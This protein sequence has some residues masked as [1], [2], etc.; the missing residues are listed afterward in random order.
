MDRRE[1]LAKLGRFGRDVSQEAQRIRSLGDSARFVRWFVSRAKRAAGWRIAKAARPLRRTARRLRQP[2]R[3][4]YRAT[5][6]RLNKTLGR[7]LPSRVLAPLRPQKHRRDDVRP[8][9]Y[10]LGPAIAASGPRAEA[11]LAASSRVERAVR[12]HTEAL[13]VDTPDRAHEAGFA[14]PATVVAL[15]E[16]DPRASVPAFDA[17]SF[18]PVG[19]TAD[20]SGPAVSLGP[21]EHLPRSKRPRRA[22]SPDDPAACRRAHHI[23]DTAAYHHD[24]IERAGALARLAAV[25]AVVHIA[26]EDDGLRRR[27]GPELYALMADD[28]I[29]TADPHQ[30]EAFSV[31]MRR[32]ALR[33]HSLRARVRQLLDPTELSAPPLPEVSILLATRHPDRAAAAVAS[34]A[35]QSYPRCELVLALHGDGFDRAAL[36]RLLQ[37]TDHPATVVEAD[38]DLPLGS[39]LN[40]ATEQSSGTLLAKFDDD[41]IYSP[42]HV[43]D[44]VLAH[45]YSRAPLVA[46]GAEYVHLTGADVTLHRRTGPSERYT[47]EGIAGG[48][49]MITRPCLDTVLGWRPIPRHIDRALIEDV[50]GAGHRIYRTHGTGYIL[51]RH[52]EGHTW[53]ADDSHYLA[54]AHHTR[55]G[56][57]RAFAGAIPANAT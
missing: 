34:A 54:Q 13:I 6:R 36:D 10:R 4:R 41:D 53:Q 46:K 18:N 15:S 40:T 47:A 31:A 25:G 9:G 21:P 12:P 2:V 55:P 1:S 28:R 29:V 50:A 39:V 22:A 57:D 33:D 38:N 14:P 56:C 44:L 49:L 20:P 16:S 24:T 45:E 26:D 19:W 8:A 48:A 35:D 23:V 52:N 37:D 5:K 7:R 30:R 51:V 42:D 43:W 11:V 27:L 32:L 3:R 17:E